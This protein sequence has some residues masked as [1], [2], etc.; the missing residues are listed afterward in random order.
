MGAEDD[1]RLSKFIQNYL[2]QNGLQVTVEKAGRQSDTKHHWN[3][4]AKMPRHSVLIPVAG[5]F[6]TMADQIQQLIN[7]Q[8]NFTDQEILGQVDALVSESMDG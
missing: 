3:T 7:S 5:V 2:Q 8:K 6:N 4:R 1:R